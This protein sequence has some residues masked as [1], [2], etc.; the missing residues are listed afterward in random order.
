MKAHFW[1]SEKQGEVQRLFRLQTT[2]FFRN[3]AK[4]DGKEVE[5]TEMRSDGV[6]KP[7]GKWD[8]YEYLGYGEYSRTEIEK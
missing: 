2:V 7:I 8:D 5:Y 4:I 6:K 1:Y 3:F